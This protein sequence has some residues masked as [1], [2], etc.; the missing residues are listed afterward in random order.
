MVNHKKKKKK[1]KKNKIKTKN[2]YFFITFGFKII[3]LNS[4]LDFYLLN[5]FSKIVKIIILIFFYLIFNLR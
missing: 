1:K 2:N 4:K 3:I 5:N